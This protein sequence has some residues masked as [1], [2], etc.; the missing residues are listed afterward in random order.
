MDDPQQGRILF[1]V[2]SAPTQGSSRS[3]FLARELA[4][5]GPHHISFGPRRGLVTTLLRYLIQGT[6]TLWL[7]W[8]KRPRVVIVQSP[9]S[10]AVLF[11]ALYCVLTNSRYVVDAHSDAFQRRIWTWPTWLYRRVARRAVVT[12]VTDTYFKQKLEGWGA[13]ALVMRS[14]VT[15]YPQEPY[16]VN[17]HFNVTVVNSFSLDEPL[18]NVLQAAAAL[19]GVR[20]YI[21][22][23]V[24]RNSEQLL[25]LAPE[26]V[27]FTNFLPEKQYYGLLKASHAVMSLTT[28]N[29][30]FQCGACE[31]LSLERPIVTSNW[32]L[33]REYFNL[34]TVHVD[35]T[36]DGIRR[37]IIEMQREYERYQGEI[38]QLRKLRY[39]EWQRRIA[40]LVALIE[41][42]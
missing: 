29:H 31:S 37:G 25:K 16:P 26:N 9:P 22:G 5:S 41:Q 8:K 28:R 39:Q 4:A 14:P 23:K 6:Q 24:R 13:K 38:V 34:G 33:L 35:N 3:R 36:V 42:G 1:L 2:W 12:L 27:Q 21:T 32:P 18:E 11:T 20:F 10:M 15:W 17:G 7:L 40:D 30:T 19:P